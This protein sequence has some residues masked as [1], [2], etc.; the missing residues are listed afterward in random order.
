MWKWLRNPTLANGLVTWYVSHRGLDS[1]DG[2][3]GSATNP[4]KTIAQATSVATE[5]QNIM[6]D[7]GIWSQQRTLNGRVFKFWGNGKTEINAS[8][9]AIT[10]YTLDLFNF[11]NVNDI[12]LSGLGSIGFVNCNALGLTGNNARVSA[13]NSKIENS[14]TFTLTSGSSVD[15]GVTNCNLINVTYLGGLVT[16]SKQPFRNNICQNVT[17]SPLGLFADYNNFTTAAIPTTGGANA[18]SIN[19]ASTGQTAAD[20]FNSVALGDYTAKVGSANLG[21]GFNK[22]DIGFSLGLT[23]YASDSIFEVVNGAEW[24]NVHY[25]NNCFKITQRDRAVASATSTELELFT[26]A[27]ATDDY[28]NGLIVGIIDGTG[29]G[30]MR[31]ITDYVGATKKAIVAAWDTIPDATSRYTITGLVISA[32]KDFGEPVKIS[33]N[34]NFANYGYNESDPG[35][36]TEFMAINPLVSSFGLKFSDFDDLSTRDWYYMGTN[37]LTLA[38]GGVGDADDTFTTGKPIHIRYAKVQIPLIFQF[39]P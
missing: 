29:V 19:N 4:F 13:V 8:V 24:R 28:Y 6:L 7:D 18:N 31:E 5:G 21:A 35:V 32:D 30:Q 38:G 11:L 39:E 3:D 1:G 26:D 23:M 37:G 22:Q 34:H 20:Y 16:A 12:S 10:T 14:G 9:V 17:N 25:D 27:E 15:F 2:G 33:R 36:W